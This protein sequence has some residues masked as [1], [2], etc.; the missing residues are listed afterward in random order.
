M[1]DKKK[2]DTMTRSISIAPES[3]DVESRTVDVI[4]ATDTPTRTWRYSIGDFMESLSFDPAHIRKARLDSGLPVLDDHNRW[5]GSS[6]VRGIA[7]SYE[8]RNGQG[9]AKLRFAKSEHDE[10]AGKIF[11][12]INDG[13]LRGVSVGYRVFKYQDMNPERTGGELP[14]YLAIDWEPTEISITPVQADA[15]SRVRA[16]GQSEE[17]PVEI[18][19]TRSEKTPENPIETTVKEETTIETK[20]TIMDPEEKSGKPEA[21]NTEA[22][23]NEGIE[24]ERKRSKAILEA[25]RKAKLDDEFAESLIEKGT[26]I[27]EA[28]ALIIEE[29]AKNDPSEGQRNTVT[30]GADETDKRR[31]AQIDSLILRSMPELKLD[32]SPTVAADRKSAARNYNGMT[33]LDL[34]KDCLIRSGQN[35][36][37]MGKMDIIGRAITSSSSDF[38]ILLEG[39][40]RRILLASY[41]AV[42]DTW[43]RFCNTGTVGDLREYKRLR[44]GTIGNLDTIGENQEY[45]TKKITDA[46][47]EKISAITKGNL[48]NVSRTM[49]LNDDLQGFTNLAGQIG[50]AAARS[51]EADVYALL[52]LNSGLGPNMTDGKTLFHADHGNIATSAV[53]TVAAIE[54]MRVLMASQKDK[55]A[56]DFLDIRPDILLCPIGLGST[57]RILNQSQY[58]PDATNKLQ[59]PNVVAGLFS[60]VIDTP[61]LTGAPYFM[62]ANPSEEPVIEVAFLDGNQSPYM[63]SKEG[64]TVDGMEWKVRLDYGVAAIGYR[65]AVRNAGV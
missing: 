6:S 36:E 43:R 48:I 39:T 65:G 45:K 32:E 8:L 42:A 17:L 12:K 41:N 59:R 1:S 13:I 34:A 11:D 38:P 4:F 16:E 55:D 28:R 54:S 44:M 26:S 9:V 62:F 46:E 35:I 61:R 51:I 49:I 63:E 24:I 2:I 50:R 25:T 31:N 37:G 60:D 15:N 53:M 33:L 19:S 64:W 58:D 29:F 23:R 56:N 40:N 14:Q 27:D 18:I 52:A 20:R 3:V 5:M 10:E 30:M 22:V 7:E 21:V 57:A 47:S